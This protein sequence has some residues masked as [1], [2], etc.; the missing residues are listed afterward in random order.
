MNFDESMSELNYIF[1]D[2]PFQFKKWKCTCETISIGVIC[3][4]CK[5]VFNEH[6]HEILDQ[7]YD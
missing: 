3:D 7:V 1:P 4:N 6:F 5:S 2:K